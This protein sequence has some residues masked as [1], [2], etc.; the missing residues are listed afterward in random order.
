MLSG[1]KSV[2]KKFWQ[3][4]FAG[5]Y[6]IGSNTD[7]TPVSCSFPGQET[8]YFLSLEINEIIIP[9][10]TEFLRSFAQ[11]NQGDIK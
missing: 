4:Y 2:Y 1:T 6:S 8:D 10:E 3:K 11:V 5:H 9:I 7:N